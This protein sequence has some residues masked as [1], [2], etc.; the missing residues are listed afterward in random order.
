M[1]EIDDFKDFCNQHPEILG[2]NLQDAWILFETKEK[3]NGY[4]V[5]FG[6]TDGKTIN[7][8]YLLEKNYNWKGIVAE[9][10][11]FWH[12]DL[13]ANRSCDIS[14][15]CVWSKSNETLEFLMT[16]APDLATISGFGKNDEHASKR[17]NN[18]VI[19]VPTISLTDLLKLKAS[20]SDI[21]YLSIDTEG[22]EYDI[23]YS[24]FKESFDNYKIDYI[25]I[26]HNYVSGFRD[27]IFRMLSMNGYE[28]KFT[29]ISRCDDFYK[30]IK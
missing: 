17:N 30:R 6:A 27:K 18:T 10:S 11:P 22:S 7:N 24:F 19:S 25:T 13:I 3:R 28:R 29:E 15:D 16:E 23:L 21:D 12:D 26:E 14:F 5:D 1:A 20:P 8:S 4:F 2:Q 9:P